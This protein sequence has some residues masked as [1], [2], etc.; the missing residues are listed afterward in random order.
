LEIDPNEK[1]EHLKAMKLKILTEIRLY[2]RKYSKLRGWEIPRNIHLMF[3]E[4]TKENSY[5]T[6]TG[7][8]N[9]TVLNKKF[10]NLRNSLYENL[11]PI[12]EG[13]ILFFYL[14]KQ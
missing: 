8:K 13:I 5:L 2:C 4:W 6:P 3:D 1:D 12:N 10:E 11:P 14:G 9:R 7:K